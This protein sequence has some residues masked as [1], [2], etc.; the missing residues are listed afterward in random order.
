MREK[1]SDSISFVFLVIQNLRAALAS[2]KGKLAKELLGDGMTSRALLHGLT[3]FLVIRDLETRLAEHMKKK[4]VEI[5]EAIKRSPAHIRSPQGMRLGWVAEITFPALWYMPEAG[6]S[7]H[8]HVY[9]PRAVQEVVLTEEGTLAI[10]GEDAM[11]VTVAPVDSREIDVYGRYYTAEGV[12]SE[13]VK[14][15]LHAHC[16]YVPTDFV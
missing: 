1:E 4:E 3:M 9:D 7:T 10:E 5:V 2:A 6:A 14:G 15:H 11:D 16:Y 8:V 13:S 12:P